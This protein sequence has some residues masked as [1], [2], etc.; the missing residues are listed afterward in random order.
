MSNVR[1][2]TQIRESVL[3]REGKAWPM[4]FQQRVTPRSTNVH[5]G[6]NLIPFA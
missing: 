3:R 4:R 6:G 1:G 2:G 5:G